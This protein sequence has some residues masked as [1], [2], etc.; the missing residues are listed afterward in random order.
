MSTLAIELSKKYVT[1]EFSNSVADAFL[2]SLTPHAIENNMKNGF[3]YHVAELNDRVVGLIGIKNNNHL[4]HL[5]VSEAH[6]NKGIGRQLWV[7]ARGA[8]I[9]AGNRDGFTVNSSRYAQKF[10]ELLGFVAQSQPQERNGMVTIPMKL[11]AD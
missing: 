3:R 4:Y 11:T 6:H 8:C 10:Y 7:V 1:P 2:S 5:F 9:A